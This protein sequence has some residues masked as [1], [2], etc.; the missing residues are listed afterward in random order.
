M[1]ATSFDE[2]S[3][4]VRG[5]THSWSEEAVNHIAGTSHDYVEDV[6]DLP[7][8]PTRSFAVQWNLAVFRNQP[9]STF[10]RLLLRAAELKVPFTYVKSDKPNA[11]G[12]YDLISI[13]PS[14]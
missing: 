9:K 14:K 8:G 7:P 13:S 12:S 3:A 6:T 5:V 10:D 1:V 2:R 4:I 11:D